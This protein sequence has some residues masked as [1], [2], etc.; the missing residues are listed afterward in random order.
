M[1][2]SN[3]S[4]RLSVAAIASALML[5]CTGCGN[6]AGGRIAPSM[7]SG[8]DQN[9]ATPLEPFKLWLPRGLPKDRRVGSCALDRVGNA[10]ADA[11]FALTAGEPLLAEG[12]VADTGRGALPKVA[13]LVLQGERGDFHV[14][15]ELGY[16]RPD[17]AEALGKR[18]LAKS[19]YHVQAS[20][21]GL[22]S[23][24]YRIAVHSADRAG[25]LTCDTR[26][27][28]RILARAS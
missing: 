22:P 9:A 25:L 6:G 19:G 27:T 10:D 23:G 12:W 3:T 16:S 17:V 7:A 5:A 21:Q 11:A 13:W 28:A 4:R 20:T 14:A 26:R 8:S 2:T 15:V 18:A 24:D 1:S